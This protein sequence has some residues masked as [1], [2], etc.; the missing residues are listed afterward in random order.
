MVE[1]QD[2]ADVLAQLHDLVH[3]TAPIRTTFTTTAVFPNMSM[4]YLAPRDS[5]PFTRLTERILARGIRVIP[6]LFMEVPMLHCTIAWFA[7][8]AE[9]EIEQALGFPNS[10]RRICVRHVIH[11]HHQADWCS[12]TMDWNIAGI[13]LVKGT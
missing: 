7:D 13:H 12:P 8:D 4:V 6:N 5:T 9:A 3:T 2:E 11:V 10:H 1:D